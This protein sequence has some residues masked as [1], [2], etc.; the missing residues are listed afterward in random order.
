MVLKVSRAHNLTVNRVCGYD[1]VYPL[2]SSKLLSQ[3]NFGNFSINFHYSLTRGLQSAA[4]KGIAP[5][6]RADCGAENP[7]DLKYSGRNGSKHPEA[8][9]LIV[10]GDFTFFAVADPGFPVGGACTR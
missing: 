3:I 6:I 4:A 9:K 8:V 7:I 1:A 2:S 10:R 5:T